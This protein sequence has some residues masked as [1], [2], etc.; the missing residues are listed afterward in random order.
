VVGHIEWV[1]FI[2]VP[3]HPRPGE[4][5]HAPECFTRAAGGG[6]VVAVVLAELG[7]E[8]DFFC[9]LGDDADGHAAADQLL[10]RG[11]RVHVAWRGEPTRRAMTL[12]EGHTERTIITI[13]KRLDPLGSDALPWERLEEA[14]GV[15]FTAGDGEALRRARA[16]G[17]L[18][19]S[20][21]ARTALTYPGAMLDA[22]VYS[23]N[24]R[25]EVQWAERLEGRARIVVQTEGAAGGRWWSAEERSEA[26]GACEGRWVAVAP[27]GEIR[28]TYGC[29]DSFAAGFT[30]ALADGASPAEAAVFGADCGARCLTRAGAP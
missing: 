15:Y 27:P 22:L 5:L 19:A 9:A 8:V 7:A 29:G 12:L 13:G 4:V 23:G 17:V 3:H 25:D 11:V 10:E 6:G 16:A 26:Q 14:E 28:D 30:Y 20:P 2:P 24:D 1:D 21:R 18:V